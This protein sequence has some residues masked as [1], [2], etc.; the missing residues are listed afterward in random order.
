MKTVSEKTECESCLVA[1][2][3]TPATT[4]SIN[5]EFS[6]YALCAQCANEYDSRMKNSAIEK[7]ITR[8][9]FIQEESRENEIGYGSPSGAFLLLNSGDAEESPFWNLFYPP[10]DGEQAD[11]TGTWDHPPPLAGLT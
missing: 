7:W 8:H 9:G 10:G 2:E 5:P 4:R 1:G 6:G 11:E 3:H